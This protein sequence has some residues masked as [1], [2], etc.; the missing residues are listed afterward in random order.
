MVSIVTASPTS[1]V[2]RQIRAMQKNGSSRLVKS[3]LSLRF[4]FFDW[5][6]E[7][8]EAIRNDQATIAGELTAIRAE[9]VD[10]SLV[11][12]WPTPA[13]LHEVSFAR[14]AFDRADDWS[15]VG[16]LDVLASLNRARGATLSCAQKAEPFPATVV[17]VP[18]SEF[19]HRSHGKDYSFRLL[20]LI[21]L[22]YGAGRR[23][24]GPRHTQI[25]TI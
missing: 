23:V 11:L 4:F 7:L 21:S 12:A 1:L 17:F 2:S 15:H 24:N 3:H 14:H 9:I 16:G 10:R 19:R 6:G 8:V 18:A 5:I 22:G 20:L 13:A 25:T